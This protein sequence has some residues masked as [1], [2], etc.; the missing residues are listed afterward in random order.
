MIVIA[1][2]VALLLLA[3]PGCAAAGI[4]AV[5]VRDMGPSIELRIADNGDLDADM[6]G[7]RKLVRRGG[8]V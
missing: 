7:G 8:K 2:L 3:G 6:G 4:E 1:R 5:Y